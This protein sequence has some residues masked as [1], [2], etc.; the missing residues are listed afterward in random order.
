MI[1]GIEYE[2]WE[3][4]VIV[5]ITIFWLGFHIAKHMYEED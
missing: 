4:I 1:W 5:G 2:K 3:I